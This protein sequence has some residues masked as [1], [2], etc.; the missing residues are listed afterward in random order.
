[1]SLGV[2]HVSIVP[3][4]DD[5]ERRPGEEL[6]QRRPPP[7]DQRFAVREQEIVEIE[8]E[9]PTKRLPQSSPHRRGVI[10]QSGNPG[11]NVSGAE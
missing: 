1:M 5:L 8:V 4:R 11:T 9:Q 6:T 2:P 3:G 10:T 7:A